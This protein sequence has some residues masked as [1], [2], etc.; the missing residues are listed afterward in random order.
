M[1]NRTIY[2]L[3]RH[4]IEFESNSEKPQYVIYG[5]ENYNIFCDN[6]YRR[7]K[8]CNELAK[9]FITRLINHDNL[10]AETRLNLL[11]S[12]LM[13]YSDHT[14][15]NDSQTGDPCIMLSIFD[16]SHI[17]Y[18]VESILKDQLKKYNLEVQFV[19]GSIYSVFNEY[20]RQMRLF[21]VMDN[22]LK[23]IKI[24]IAKRDD[25]ITDVVYGSIE[26]SVPSKYQCRIMGFIKGDHLDVN[27]FKTLNDLETEKF[28]E[29]WLLKTLITTK[30]TLSSLFNIKSFDLN[31][32]GISFIK[33]DRDPV[34]REFESSEPEFKRLRLFNKFLE[35]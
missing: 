33:T 22:K 18:L 31:E 10:D 30:F 14:I 1:N 27:K 6:I 19:I 8:K 34:F 2:L 21:L 35:D 5:D 29:D 26:N 4:E 32:Q 17:K 25:F 9:L 15:V 23:S 3:T 16:F 28:L 11:C 24:F 20:R 7:F 13:K 12:L